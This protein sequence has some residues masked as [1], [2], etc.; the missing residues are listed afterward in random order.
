M[1]KYLPYIFVFLVFIVLLVLAINKKSSV[2]GNV[3]IFEE[4]TKTEQL[5]VQEENKPSNIT[6]YDLS[7]LKDLVKGDDIAESYVREL[8]W[9]ITHNES[10]HILHSTSFM[11]DYIKTGKDVSC[12]PHELWHV[13]L[14][15]KHGDM[16]Y[17]KKQAKSVEKSYDA[18]EKSVDEKRKAYPQF[19][20]TLDELKKRIQN[21]LIK[22]KQNDYSNDTLEELELIGTVGLC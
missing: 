21:M 18:W 5:S 8:E 1:K 15:A 7:K 4:I 16:D 12:V 6:S 17:A 19:Y 3:A 13:S 22:L 11:R 20:K 10:Q 2:I 9:L 14:F